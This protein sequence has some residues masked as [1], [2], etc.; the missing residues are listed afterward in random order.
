MEDIEMSLSDKEK[1]IF[2]RATKTY[3]KLAQFYV[4]VEEMAELTVEIMN[5]CNRGVFNEHKI[6]EEIADVEIMMEQ[7]K[8]L[9]DVDDSS[10]PSFVEDF[11]VSQWRDYKV[12]RLEERLND[13]V[14]IKEA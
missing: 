14:F 12:R 6:R 9:V 13:K 4:A 5:H 3:G 2:N 1:E 8:L 11:S 10:Y 7:L